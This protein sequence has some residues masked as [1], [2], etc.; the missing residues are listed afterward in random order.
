MIKLLIIISFL[1]VPIVYSEDLTFDDLLHMRTRKDD[2]IYVFLTSKQWRYSGANKDEK[3]GYQET[4]WS[5][6]PIQKDAPVHWLSIFRKDKKH[7]RISYM[8]GDDMIFFA[9]KDALESKKF[10][11]IDE[12]ANDKSLQFV[13]SDK[14]AVVSVLIERRFPKPWYCVTIYSLKDYKKNAVSQ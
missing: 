4:I 1:I 10:T 12:K 3:T 5:Y 6:A 7:I 11:L 2:G 9:I 14:R 13:Y 8:F